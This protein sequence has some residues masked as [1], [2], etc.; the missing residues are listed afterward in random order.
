[1]YQM[2]TELYDVEE[3]LAL[4]RMDLEK[5]SYQESL[6]KIKLAMKKCKQ[7]EEAYALAGRVYAQIGLYEKAN[8]AYQAFIDHNPDATLERFQLGMSLF[9]SGEIEQAQ[10]NWES[11]L[12]ISPVYAP[13]LYYMAVSYLHTDNIDLTRSY[14]A[15]LLSSVEP[16]NYYYGLTQQLLEKL[17]QEEQVESQQMAVDQKLQLEV[18]ETYKV[19]N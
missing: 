10:K 19:V 2:Y 9:D 3:L 11:L 4:A 14:S 15:T 16:D 6:W 7:G 5:N 17:E 18:N 13:A 12:E 1:M 8:V